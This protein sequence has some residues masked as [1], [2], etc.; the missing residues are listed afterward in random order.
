MP[1]KA[2][3]RTKPLV[4]LEDCFNQH[5]PCRVVACLLGPPVKRTFLYS[6]ELNAL[7]SDLR[8]GFSSYPRRPPRPVTFALQGRVSREK[9]P[10]G[11]TEDY[12][13][14]EKRAGPQAAHERWRLT[15]RRR[16]CTPTRRSRRWCRARCRRWRCGA[17]AH[18]RGCRERSNRVNHVA[19][20]AMNG[21]D[22]Q[23]AEAR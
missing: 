6:Y 2:K 3:A 18:A 22:A 17:A 5:R 8:N 1:K 7:H 11:Q 16:C 21:P 4:L 15:L 10:R 9:S 12:A 23:S 13:A 20:R 14:T 19:R